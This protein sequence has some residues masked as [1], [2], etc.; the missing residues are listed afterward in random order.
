MG[1]RLGKH[2]SGKFTPGR[3]PCPGPAQGGPLSGC[4][5]KQQDISDLVH[6]VSSVEGSS[7]QDGE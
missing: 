7:D 6:G 5:G 4:G 3:N 2:P 1:L